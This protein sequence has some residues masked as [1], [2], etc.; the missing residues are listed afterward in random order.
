ME[1]MKRLDAIGQHYSQ[2]STARTPLP[3]QQRQQSRH[4]PGPPAGAGGDDD[5]PPAPPHQD[6]R[7]VLRHDKRR[8]ISR[9]HL[10]VLCRTIF[11]ARMFDGE[12]DAQ[13]GDIQFYSAS[14]PAPPPT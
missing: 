7:A 4:H 1:L 2:P 9:N 14:L 3:H 6:G 13:I 12:D 11:S 10:D 8:M 5:I